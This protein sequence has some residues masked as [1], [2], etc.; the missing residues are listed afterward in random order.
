VHAAIDPIV[1]GSDAYARLAAYA[2]AQGWR[3]ALLVCDAN[4]EEAAGE[5]VAAQLSPL[6]VGRLRFPQR[7]GLRADE[8]ALAEVRTRLRADAPDGLIA[9][10]SGVITDIVRYAA[11]LERRDFVSVP[12][13]ASM[14][15]YASGVA[16]L[17]I[18]GVKVTH[19]ARV[20]L[21][22][23]AD[24]EVLAAAPAELA[25]SGLGDT[26]GKATAR[27][28]WLAS[29]LLY[30]ERFCPAADARVLRTL[31]AVLD[32]LGPVLKGDRVAIEALT[33]ALLESGIAMAMVGSSRP[34]S[35]CEHHASHL[36]DLM[37]ARGLRERS[38]HGLQV[39]YATHYAIRLQRFAFAGGVEDLS[40]PA[41]LP[42]L[43]DAARELLGGPAAAIS[44]AIEEKR[45]FLAD[46]A[47]RWPAPERWAEVRERLAP[48]LELLPRIEAALPEA[49]IPPD[50][51]FLDIDAETLRETFRY[52]SHLRGR[53]TTVDFLRGQGA[54]EEALEA[55]LAPATSGCAR[56]GG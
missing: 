6:G 43:D 3:S 23:F 1:I 13:A 41:D 39:G 38:P 35:G 27:V 42:P 54:L 12:T 28:D 16:A 55:M 40:P 10:G 34:A 52:A 45:R 7:S 22:I 31:T 30:G 2:Q 21:A 15:G 48:A 26:F 14:D 50:P 53:Y 49:G 36:W 20:P 33:R 32:L 19:P 37:A 11:H 25:R 24:P 56:G 29:N 46:S 9:V 17:Q 51:G 47:S 5:L 18:D 8:A 44:A 4:T